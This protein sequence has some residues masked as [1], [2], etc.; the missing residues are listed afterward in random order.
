MSIMAIAT[1]EFIS[2]IIE[3]GTDPIRAE[4]L[5]IK[6]DR[7]RDGEVTLSFNVVDKNGEPLVEIR[8]SE[9]L[10]AGETLTIMR[11]DAVFNITVRPG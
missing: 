11:L 4:G 7:I 10:T 3:S 6:V 1:K 8:P 5:T 9:S 2:R